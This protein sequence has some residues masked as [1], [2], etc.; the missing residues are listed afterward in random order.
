MGKAE[1]GPKFAAMKKMVTK[2]SIKKWVSFFFSLKFFLYYS[3]ISSNFCFY[4]LDS[5]FS[6]KQQVLDPKKNDNNEKKLPR[7]V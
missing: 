1:K 4:V 6:Y 7:N 3:L 5:L 2:K